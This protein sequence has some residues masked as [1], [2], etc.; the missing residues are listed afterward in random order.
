MAME[1]STEK[2]MV[3]T[4]KKSHEWMMSIID[5]SKRAKT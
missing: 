4:R 5:R 3:Q 2:T 1:P